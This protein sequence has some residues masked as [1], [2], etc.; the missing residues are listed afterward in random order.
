MAGTTLHYTIT[1]S[2]P[3]K[4]TIT[5]RPGPAYS[6]GVYASGLVVRRSLALN[7]DT[8]HAIAANKR[9]RYAMQLTVPSRAAAGI[10]KFSWSLNNPHGPFAGRIIQITRR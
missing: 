6:E 1:L 9:V 8:I 2:N 7:C 3:T 5:L 4:T 10:A